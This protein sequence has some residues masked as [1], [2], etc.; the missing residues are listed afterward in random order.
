MRVGICCYTWAHGW[1]MWV[2]REGT[3]VGEQRHMGNLSIPYNTVLMYKVHA[4]QL[5]DPREEPGWEVVGPVPWTR[6][7]G[8]PRH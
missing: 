2:T 3:R 8:R 6:V 4:R 7:P 5:Q 1:E